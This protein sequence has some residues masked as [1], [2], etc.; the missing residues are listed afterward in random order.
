MKIN[1]LK[2]LLFI[3]I[4]LAIG[5]LVNHFLT[6]SIP[7]FLAIIFLIIAAIYIFQNPANGLILIAFFLPFERIGS[8]DIAGVT[9]RLS[10]VLALITMAAWLI[11]GLTKKEIKPVK[12]PIYL[13][14]VLFLLINI[15]ALVNSP[16]LAKSILVLGFT[17]FTILVSLLIPNLVKETATLQKIIKTLLWSSLLVTLFGLYQF[18]GDMLGLPET[19][20]GL[21]SQ[22]TKVILGFTRVQSTALEPLYFANYLLIPICLAVVLFL[23]K[24]RKFRP[25]FLL[26]IIGLGV[27]NLILTASR[28]GYLALLA[29][30]IV[31]AIFYWRKIFSLKNVIGLLAVLILIVFILPKIM[32]LAAEENPL[33]PNLGQFISHA[34]NLFGGAAYEERVERY[35]QALNLWHQHPLIGSGPGSFGP[36][37]AIHPLQQPEEGWAIVNNEPLELLAETGIFGLVIMGLIVIILIIR[38]LALARFTQNQEFKALLVAFLAAFIGIIVQYQTFSI[39][40][41]MHIWFTIGM[42]IAIQNIIKTNQ[43]YY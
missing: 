35:E 27:L 39:L 31:I 1:F 41:I 21:R 19:L 18:A 8:Y 37:V 26:S 36:L 9:V 28:G 2:L 22:Y 14:L 6:L 43:D 33:Q 16:N 40:Y 29:S 13:P 17:I 5:F 3:F 10:Q 23:N 7:L 15:I 32:G 20:T 12:N 30:L 38:S 34:K 11:E 42:L 24:N 4:A 25:L